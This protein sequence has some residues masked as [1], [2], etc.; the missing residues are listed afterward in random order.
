MP[1]KIKLLVLE[2]N[3]IFQKNFLEFSEKYSFQILGFNKTAKD[4][5]QQIKNEKPQVVI[6]DLVIPE[7]NI[8]ELIQT[9]K[10]SHPEIPLIACSSL[11]ED[12]IVSKVLKAGCFDY[13][14]KP[15][16]EDDLAEAIKKAVA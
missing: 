7:E 12:H 15:L 3:E 13:I 8:L 5:L 6:L 1:E 2:D 16:K 14:F 9:I 10:D 11:K 4:L